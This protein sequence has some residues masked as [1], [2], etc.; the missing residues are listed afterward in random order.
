M[1]DSWIRWYNFCC[2]PIRPPLRNIMLK[3]WFDISAKCR[4]ISPG[5]LLETILRT[6]WKRGT[7]Q[8]H[9][10]LI[11]WIWPTSIQNVTAASWTRRPF[12]SRLLQ[13]T[14]VKLL[15]RFFFGLQKELNKSQIV[16]IGFVLTIKKGSAYRPGKS[17]DSVTF[18]A[19]PRRSLHKVK[20]NKLLYTFTALASM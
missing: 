10:Q 5:P 17:N 3:I 7:A 1:E 8:S 19:G 20:L 2:N 16:S 13:I 6:F 4:P 15:L 11:P 9:F 18:K 12:L 14:K